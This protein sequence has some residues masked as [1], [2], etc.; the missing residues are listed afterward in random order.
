MILD[1]TLCVN[2]V[3][4]SFET[5]KRYAFAKHRFFN[6]NKFYVGIIII[7]LR[8]EFFFFEYVNRTVDKDARLMTLRVHEVNPKL[9]RNNISFAGFSAWQTG[10][11][12]MRFYECECHSFR[13]SPIVNGLEPS[14]T[15]VLNLNRF[16]QTRP[17]SG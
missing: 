12:N 14:R 7:L 1:L 8:C 15:S 10:G 5:L 16:Y 2:F 6:I 4:K 11:S 17:V 13:K 3:A 9:T